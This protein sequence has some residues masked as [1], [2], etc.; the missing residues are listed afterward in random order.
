MWRSGRA[1]T[2]S[3][4]RY[5]DKADSRGPK[6]RGVAFDFVLPEFARLAKI[7]RLFPRETC[8]CAVA[9]CERGVGNGRLPH[10]TASGNETNIG[11]WP[12]FPRRRQS[13]IKS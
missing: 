8:A 6:G 4:Q 11:P 2:L 1:E 3:A 5:A 13:R 10:S 12:S 7:A 9:A